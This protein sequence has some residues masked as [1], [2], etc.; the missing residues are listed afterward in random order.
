MIS[1]APTQSPRLTAPWQW[2][3]PALAVFL[4]VLPLAARA[5]AQTPP[6]GASVEAD[7]VRCWWRTDRAAIRMGEPS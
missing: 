3:I 1:A 4:C 6:A 7:P 5:Q 2:A